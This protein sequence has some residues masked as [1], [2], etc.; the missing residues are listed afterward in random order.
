VSTQMTLYALDEAD[1]PK[2]RAQMAGSLGYARTPL[3]EAIK[4]REFMTSPTAA[5]ERSA[6]YDVYERSSF[7][8]DNDHISLHGDGDDCVAHRISDLIEGDLPVIDGA[9]IR[10][11]L[12]LT[13]GYADGTVLVE[14]PVWTKK[15]PRRLKR[16]AKW[17]PRTAEEFRDA[18]A[19]WLEGARGRRLW[20]AYV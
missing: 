2:A 18:L 19:A 7:I 12:A 5:A 8:I 15:E 9:L 14:P 16:A 6:A 10:Q 1:L 11:V 20:Y 4:L 3:G 13:E 17:R